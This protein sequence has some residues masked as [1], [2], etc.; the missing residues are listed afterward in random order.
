[1]KNA[2]LNTFIT[3]VGKVAIL[4]LNFA[5]VVLTTRFWGA[6]GRGVISLFV[7][8]LG[9]IAIFANVFNGSSV[10]YYI[11]RVSASKLGTQAYIWALLIA[12]VGALFEL[13]FKTPLLA[14]LFFAIACLAACLS[15]HN[16]LYIGKQKIKAYNLIT[17]IQPA[18]I[19]LLTLLFSFLFPQITYYAYFCAYLLATFITLGIASRITRKEIEQVK[20]QWDRRA[21]KD[22]FLF[23]WK[24]ELS[25]LL[26]FFNY[27][28][29]YYVLGY[30]LG[31]ASVGI[32]SI[33]VTLSEAIWILSRSISLVQYS[34]VLQE[35]NTQT[36]RRH[37]ARAAL[38]SAIGSLLCLVVALLLPVQLYTFI[39]GEE[40]ASV[41]IIL[42]ILSPGILAIAISNVYGNYFSATKQLNVL[43]IKSLAGVLAT[44]VLA[45][46]LVP[47]LEIQGACIVNSI[48]YLLSSTIL[49]L[50]YLLG[51]RKM[52]NRRE[53]DECE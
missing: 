47:T 14:L 31:N 27:R 19:L 45:V 43:I 7:A 35:G 12:L 2:K 9:L 11:Q 36:A 40:F 50:A 48:S 24:T 23:G 32:F 22:S 25:S 28:L 1:M 53:E 6:A 51:G 41:K 21:A 4:L 52:A 38:F 5:I 16:A 39:F 13:C 18:L 30:Y 20:F 44:A 26:Q 46:V 42:W 49:I 29:T 10:S 37:T 17:V 33:G 15:F 8:D 34:Q 3:L